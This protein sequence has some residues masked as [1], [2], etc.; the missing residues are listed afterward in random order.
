MK[1][2]HMAISQSE[3]TTQAPGVSSLPYFRGMFPLREHCDFSEIHPTE[4]EN[5]ECVIADIDPN[6]AMS[7]ITRREICQFILTACNSHAA[8]LA[9]IAELTD[10]L[11][12]VHDL[13]T[14]PN[15]DNFAAD[16]IVPQIADVLAKQ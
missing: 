11:Q 10:M 9:R 16:S 8:N 12:A 5:G 4:D 14:D 6:C 13:L 2:D 7:D 15:A 1:T 3:P